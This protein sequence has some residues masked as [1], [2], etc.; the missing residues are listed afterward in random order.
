MCLCGVTRYG[1]GLLFHY[2]DGRLIMLNVDEN[3]SIG[4]DGKLEAK[5]NAR[6]LFDIP[7]PSESMNRAEGVLSKD[8]SSLD[9]FITANGG[10]YGYW[11][12][13]GAEHYECEDWERG[14][15][16]DLQVNDLRVR[17]PAQVRRARRSL[18]GRRSTWLRLRLGDGGATLIANPVSVEPDDGRTMPQ[19]GEDVM[20]VLGSNG[21]V[22]RVWLRPTTAPIRDA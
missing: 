7:A 6:V 15:R 3:T 9:H 5:D 11:R 8:T 20:V 10:P 19:V 16:W 13:H 2:E 4:H 12:R 22:D 21:R 18:W 1:K 17:L 14:F